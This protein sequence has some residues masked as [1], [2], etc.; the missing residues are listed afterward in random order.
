MRNARDLIGNK[1]I[2]RFRSHKDGK[3]FSSTATP[4][5]LQGHF[6]TVNH[7]LIDELGA[8]NEIVFQKTVYPAEIIKRWPDRDLM[9][10]RAPIHLTPVQTFQI[11]STPL[12]DGQ[13]VTIVGLPGHGDHSSRQWWQARANMKELTKSGFVLAYLLPRKK[14]PRIIKGTSGGPVVDSQRRLVGIVAASEKQM[15]KSFMDFDPKAAEIFRRALSRAYIE[16]VLKAKVTYYV[17]W[18]YPISEF[19]SELNKVLCF[20]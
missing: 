15:S 13:K 4:I 16:T 6:L 8:N 17:T 2:V 14:R 11:R 1:T 7:G 12:R 9:L 18:F 10:V 19:V 3:G 5:D 20:R